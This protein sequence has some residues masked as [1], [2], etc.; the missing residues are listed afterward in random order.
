[1]ELRSKSF[2]IIAMQNFQIRHCD[3]LRFIFITRIFPTSKRNNFSAHW[4]IVWLCLIKSFRRET[5]GAIRWRKWIGTVVR[6]IWESQARKSDKK[7][8][9]LMQI[10]Y[11]RLGTETGGTR[12]YRSARLILYHLSIYSARRKHMHTHVLKSRDR[13]IETYIYIPILSHNQFAF[14]FFIFSRLQKWK[15]HCSSLIW[16]HFVNMLPIPN[17]II[18]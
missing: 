9:S 12:R 4:L 8:I 1:M 7:V 2:Q 16:I 13:H 14:L 11:N 17:Q 18:I 10:Y 5:V 6:S 3:W 15:H